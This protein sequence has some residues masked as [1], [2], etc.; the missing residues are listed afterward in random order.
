MFCCSSCLNSQNRPEGWMVKK[1][2]KKVKKSKKANCTGGDVVLINLA[3]FPLSSPRTARWYLPP[4]RFLLRAAQNFDPINTGTFL[5]SWMNHDTIFSRMEKFDLLGSKSSRFCAHVCIHWQR[6]IN[7]SLD[8]QLQW[9]RL[10][11]VEAVA[12]V[13]GSLAYCR[14]LHVLRC[15]SGRL[16]WL[17]WL[18]SGSHDHQ[19]IHVAHAFTCLYKSWSWTHTNTHI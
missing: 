9:W 16:F 14:V 6:K 4:E 12:V 10:G 8:R 5:H 2:N 3:F 19:I 7:G 18:Q 17:P 11:V 15:S 1:L 13:E